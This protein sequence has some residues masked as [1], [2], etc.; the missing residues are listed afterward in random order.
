MQQYHYNEPLRHTYEEE[1]EHINKLLSQY[2]YLELMNIYLLR[3]E[4]CSISNCDILQKLFDR[5]I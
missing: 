5:N 3:T 1:T 4:H 2:N